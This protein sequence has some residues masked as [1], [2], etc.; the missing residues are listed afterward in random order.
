MYV[1]KPSVG[2]CVRIDQEM[3]A[4]VAR[5]SAGNDVAD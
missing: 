2:K 3:V 5:A 4:F 1:Q